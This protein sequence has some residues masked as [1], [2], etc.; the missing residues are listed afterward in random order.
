[1]R[2]VVRR[3]R[4]RLRARRAG[5]GLIGP[6]FQTRRQL[7]RYRLEFVTSGLGRRIARAERQFEADVRGTTVRGRRA[8]W[9]GLKRRPASMLYA[10]LR[11][12]R[13]DVVVETGVCNGASSAVLLAALAKNDRGRL[14][15]ID[16][17]EYADGGSA[18]FWEG[19]GGSVVPS[20]QQPGW[21]IPENLR[22]RWELT[23]G[24]SQET[25]PPLLERLGTIDVFIHDSEHSYECMSFEYQAAFPHLRAGGLLISDDVHATKAFREFARDHHR[26]SIPLETNTAALVK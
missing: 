24:R 15:S 22:D 8:R 4:K 5:G 20:G 25:L 16:L 7:W 19:K 26:Q 10:T 17:P 13:P 2:E 6:V 3:A 21:I 1:M 11:A 14:Y 9:G 23:L 12:I 18:E